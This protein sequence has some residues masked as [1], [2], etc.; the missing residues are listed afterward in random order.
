MVPT[1]YSMKQNKDY[2]TVVT[3][4]PVTRGSFEQQSGQKKCVVF[5][6]TYHTSRPSPLL[7]TLVLLWDGGHLRTPDNTLTW[8]T[9]VAVV[10]K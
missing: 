10:L 1:N 7:L 9:S 2:V 4:E 8:P 6:H 3:A 5:A